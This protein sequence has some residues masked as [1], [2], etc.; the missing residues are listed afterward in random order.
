MH[1]SKKL[2]KLGILAVPFD[3]LPLSDVELPV[4]FENVVWKNTHDLL[5][6][7][8][9]A[10]KLGL[11]AIMLTNFGCGPDSFATTMLDE[12][13]EDHP[14]LAIEVDDHSAD[15]GIVTRL[16]AFLHTAKRP[17]PKGELQLSHLETVT[18]R[19]QSTGNLFSPAKELMET[20]EGRTLYIP[21]ICPG[22]TEILVAALR[23]AGFDA[24]SLPP[25]DARS[26]ELGHKYAG[27]DECHPHIVTVGDFVKLTERPDFDPDQSAL[28]MLNYDGA[29]RL[30]Q[31]PLAEKMVM[32]RL[33]FEQVPVIA[34]IV[35]TRRDEL[36][37]MFG[38]NFVQALWKGWVA[39]E[40]LQRHLFAIR[41]YQRVTGQADRVYGDAVGKIA[42][43]ISKFSHWSYLS[44]KPLVSALAQGVA[45][46]KA[47]P[48]DKNG[49]RPKI[50]VLG[51]FFTLLN[52]AV[53]FDLVRQ[54]ESLG[55][56]VTTQGFAITNIY[57]FAS[58]RYYAQQHWRNK[59]RF[60]SLYYF[61]RKH[62]LLHW[63]TELEKQLD[64]DVG[65]FGLMR[66]AEIMR[67]IA[68]Y[69]HYDLDPVATTLIARTVDF[70]KDGVAGIYCMLVLNCMLAN[71]AL[72]IMWRIAADHGGLP[73]LAI[74][75]DGNKPTNILTRL[76]A[77]V[78]QARGI[79]EKQLSR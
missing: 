71:T 2:R 6:A 41:P 79:H 17:Q 56:E 15:A 20:L 12:V 43:A 75:Y 44:D 50:G 32:K 11:P 5:R 27:G 28:F 31:F 60:S 52:P 18:Q 70:A 65:A 21:Y 34:P 72:P 3:F 53:N 62:W 49:E 14:H 48:V 57:L 35:S 26:L 61:M 10:R 29:C 33:G 24:E 36:T 4:E 59:K 74:P 7:A 51:E 77:F 8:V 76:E 54:L 67:N 58:E 1:I 23:M 66:D 22:M 39:A 42:D 68:D 78:E 19:K 55:V 47:V 25:Q 30:S 45:D 64:E 63:A 37:R 38:L 9:L 73:I 69:L 13:F 16:E 40:I 46:I